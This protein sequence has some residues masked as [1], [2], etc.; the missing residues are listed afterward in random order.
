MKQMV[1]TQ[2]LLAD[3]AENGS[4][5]AFRELVARYLNLVY[6]T[7][8]R[9]MDR[10]V[11][12]AE[13]VTQM[14]FV[15][16]SRH[17]RKLSREPFLGG[18]LHRDT[19]YEAAK[20]LRRERR[21]QAREQQ[22]AFMNSL[23]DHSEANFKTI[24]PVL[25]EAINLLGAEDRAAILLRFF[26]RRDF[27]A[28]GAALGSNEDAAR[29]RVNRA[30]D[31]LRS[32]LHR[33]GVTLSAAAL[34][35]ALTGEVVSAAPAGLAA[36]VAG[37]ALAASAA[38]GGISATLLKIMTLTKLKA[39]L[40]GAIVI[41]GVATSLVI[42][43][44]ARARQRDQDA[45]LRQQSEQL[46]Q[47]TAENARLSNLA[48]PAPGASSAGNLDELTKLRT[49]AESLR[50]QSAGL[51]A[52]REQHRRLQAR[53]PASSP[54]P[55]TPL[56]MQEENIARMSF[57]KSWMLG[58]RLYAQDYD[59][60]FPA[61]FDQLVPDYAPTDRKDKEDIKLD[62]FEIVYHGSLNAITNPA[63]TMVLREKQAR[64]APDGRWQ[65][66]YGFA[67]GHSEVHTEADGNFDAFEKSR[68]ISRP[69]Q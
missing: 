34:T 35:A 42:Q 43:S 30:L 25:D 54:K 37:T 6:S 39:G 50:Q 29:M 47:L 57:A 38:G 12:S 44:Q 26:E 23:T 9:L 18:W 21:R 10:N 45:L 53:N 58:V 5:A 28:V 41:T 11:Q 20:T 33:R 46:A 27:R 67:D 68:I 60:N 40:G 63:N 64:Q 62:E 51:A 2:Q 61:N 3:Y 48:T 59:G 31:K 14:V 1:E 55:Q 7:A 32:L 69:P 24:A 52:L 8:L 36:T 16:L 17:A 15:H 49:E 65:K 56:Q 19:C 66:A 4:E 13:D 22:A